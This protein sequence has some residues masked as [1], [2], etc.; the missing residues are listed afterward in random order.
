M[1]KQAHTS[2]GEAR[3]NT[4]AV[5]EQLRSFIER[6]ER[7]NDEKQAIAED[8]KDVKAEAKAMG[9]D[10]KTLNEMIKLRAM[11]KADREEREHLR[12]TY[13]HALGVFG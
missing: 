6:I 13:A 11:D 4:G 3:P 9:F 2:D 8:I 12:D 7:L 5:G 1:D 10:V